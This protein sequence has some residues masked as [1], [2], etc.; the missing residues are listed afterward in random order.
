[1]KIQRIYA[2]KSNFRRPM[3]VREYLWYRKG[4]GCYP[5]CP[6]CGISFEREYAAFCS[7]CG[8]RLDWT[9]RD[10]RLIRLR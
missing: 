2:V 1:M 8:Q 6:R 3:A 4:G 10:R 5:C 9:D 7:C